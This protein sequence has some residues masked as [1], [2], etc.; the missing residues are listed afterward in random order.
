MSTES[1]RFECAIVVAKRVTLLS[2]AGLVGS[3]ERTHCSGEAD[4]I[5]HRY[6]A[7]HVGHG[8][9][10]FGSVALAHPLD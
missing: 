2:R 10:F 8:G 4:S 3:I 7:L 1:E 9:V 6:D 5:D